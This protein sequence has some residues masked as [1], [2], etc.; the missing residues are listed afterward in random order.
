MDARFAKH[1]MDLYS[2]L[3]EWRTCVRVWHEVLLQ[4]SVGQLCVELDEEFMLVIPCVGLGRGVTEAEVGMLAC[5]I[6]RWKVGWKGVATLG[7]METTGRSPRPTA[8]VRVSKK[9]DGTYVVGDS[10][11]VRGHSI[12]LFDAPV[13][14]RLYL[15]VLDRQLHPSL[16]RSLCG[17]LAVEPAGRHTDVRLYRFRDECAH[18]LRSPFLWKRL[19]EVMWPGVGLVTMMRW[20]AERCRG[21]HAVE[22]LVHSVIL[23]DELLKA[24]D[25]VILVERDAHG[26]HRRC[27]L[28][29]VRESQ[30]RADVG[31]VLFVSY[32]GYEARV[33]E[34]VVVL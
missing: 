16:F 14:M 31:S 34:E 33:G 4:R 22:S 26:R 30:W 12:L 3:K 19:A 21:V 24:S 15:D 18:R 27:L 32:V 5:L 1:L 23:L 7:A 6:S 2:P 20:H 25:P 9:A 28:I 10:F 13:Y 8:S 17:A 29:M 11:C